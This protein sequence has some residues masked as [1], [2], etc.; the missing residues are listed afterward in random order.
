MKH[1]VSTYEMLANPNQGR[2]HFPYKFW[3]SHQYRIHY[4]S[5]NFHAR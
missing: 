4:Q 2:S 3:S 5:D 1:T